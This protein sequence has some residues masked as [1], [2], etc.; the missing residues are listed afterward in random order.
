MIKRKS[1]EGHTEVICLRNQ[2]EYWKTKYENEESKNL[3]LSQRLKI[4]TSNCL[5]K[6]LRS[7]T[8]LVQSQSS[9]QFNISNSQGL[10]N[11][12]GNNNF[13][14]GKSVISNF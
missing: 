14:E 4:S 13:R 8:N 3:D 2:V 1:L 6:F 7:Q 12:N 5:D 10:L 11:N 9:I